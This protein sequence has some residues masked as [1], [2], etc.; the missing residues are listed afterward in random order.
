M[1]CE[2][3]KKDRN[4]VGSKTGSKNEERKE[5]ER[6]MLIVSN[7]LLTPLIKNARLSH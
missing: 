3:L 6:K 2:T 5:K 4:G 1:E 7:L